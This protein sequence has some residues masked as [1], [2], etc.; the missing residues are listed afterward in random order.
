MKTVLNQTPAPSDTKLKRTGMAGIAAS[1]L[2]L[3]V[4]EVPIILAVLGLG[5]L[6]A[7]A[8]VLRPPPMVELGAIVAMVVGTLLLAVVVAR[9]LRQRRQT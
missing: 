3:L 6:S 5:G 4:C 9:R 7:G 8:A 1:V 2:A